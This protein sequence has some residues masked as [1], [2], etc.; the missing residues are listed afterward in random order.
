MED[1]DF[2]TQCIPIKFFE[3]LGPRVDRQVC[4]QLPVDAFAI[5]GRVSFLRMDDRE[6][7]CWILLLLRHRRQHPQAAIFEFEDRCRSFALPVPYGNAMHALDG[8]LCHL[9]LHLR[10]AVAGRAVGAGAHEEMGARIVRGAEQLVDVA[11]AVTDMHTPSRFTQQS[12]GMLQVLQTAQTLLLVDGHPRGIDLPLQS[13]RPL[14]FLP[15]PKLHGRQAERQSGR[16]HDETRMHRNAAERIV[17]PPRI[18][19]PVLGLVQQPD[20]FPPEGQLRGVVQYQH[21]ATHPRKPLPGRAKV[22]GQ[23]VLLGHPLVG[24]KS[25]GRLR[26]G[27][28]L[29]RQWDALRRAV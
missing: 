11:F 28:I 9:F 26:I 10:R 6:D 29:A 15:S 18:A 8:D 27:P 17:R 19:R 23:D 22:P 3:G 21:G 4:D 25:I 13:V 24:E 2:P 16:R 7:E 5:L 14:E 20:I 1:F 12:G